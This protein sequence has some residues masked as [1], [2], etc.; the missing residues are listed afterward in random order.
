MIRSTILAVLLASFTAFAQAPSKP[1]F[2]VASVKLVA[3]PFPSGSGPWIV[4]HGMFRVEISPVKG[5]IR[6]AYDVPPAGVFGGPLW[7]ER[8][9]Y[10]FDAKAE[11]AEAGPDQLKLMVRSLL[12]DRFKLVAHRETQERHMY[13][14]VV[15]KNGPKMEKAKADE[16]TFG[17]WTGPGSVTFTKMNMLGLVN[18]LSSLLETQVVDKTGLKDFYNFR[19]EYE[20]PRLQRS[21]NGS[22]STADSAPSIF[23]AVQDQLGLKLEAIKG[24]VEV[25]VIDHIERPMEN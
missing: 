15:G 21:Q 18:V 13:T 1:T 20:N 22:Q 23:T 16:K 3:P 12:E 17:N 11:N 6:W 5:V 10:R 19:L 9:P 25:L 8:E 14:L 7:V 4:Y 24:L 2:E